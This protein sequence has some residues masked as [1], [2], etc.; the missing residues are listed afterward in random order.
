M[1]IYLG[2]IDCASI[3]GH[4]PDS[5][6]ALD[7]SEKIRL[8]GFSGEKRRQEFLA[9]R[10]LSKSM[11]A[12][13]LGLKPEDLSLLPDNNGK[14]RL[15]VD[16]KAA[17]AAGIQP[18]DE[19]L[20]LSIAHSERL[21]AAALSGEEIGLDLE[22]TRK[23]RNFDALA[24]AAFHP[25]EGRQLASLDLDPKHAEIGAASAKAD[26][27]YLLW[28]LKEACLKRRGLGI[29][30]IAQSPSFTISP[31]ENEGAGHYS[32]QARPKEAGDFISFALGPDFIASI[33][34]PSLPP[35][36]PVQLVFDPRFTPRGRDAARLL[37][38]T[39]PISP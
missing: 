9:G 31:R 7:S 38:A 14:P 5:G 29:D 25:E 6:P 3:Q 24:L 16:S 28:T 12:S 39:C 10:L 8:E 4:A 26:F 36:S 23:T 22:C 17:K 33:S 35:D 19:A 27:F 34:L 1:K 21:V 32:I 18:P 2:V 13:I 30:S 15:H 37:G 20:F 11:A